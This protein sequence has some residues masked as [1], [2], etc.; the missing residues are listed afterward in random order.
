MKRSDME[1][2]MRQTLDGAAARCAMSALDCLVGAGLPPWDPEEPEVLWESKAKSP[3]YCYRLLADG[4]WEQSRGDEWGEPPSLRADI[5]PLL[6][7]LA[8]RILEERREEKELDDAMDEAE[9][10]F[11][12]DLRKL[13][14]RKFHLADGASYW[15]IP[16]SEYRKFQDV[17]HLWGPDGTMRKKL[18]TLQLPIRAWRRLRSEL[19]ALPWEAMK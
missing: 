18:A 11:T 8:R 10:K 19:L 2:V 17:W 4:R 9:R 12:E 14:Q 6:D 5:V 1:K 3:L 13:E 15:Q 16:H 7:E